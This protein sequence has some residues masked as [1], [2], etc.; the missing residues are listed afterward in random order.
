[1]YFWENLKSMYIKTLA[2]IISLTAYSFVVSQSIN[3]YG[4]MPSS[5]PN[6]D[7]IRLAE[8]DAISGD[9]ITIDSVKPVNAYAFGTSAFDS[10]H[11]AYSFIGVDPDQ[12][13]RF[14]NWG[15]YNDTMYTMPPVS[16]T[17]NDLE[18]DMQALEFYGLGSYAINAVTGEY[19]L[20]FL[21]IDQVTGE[22]NELK[23]MPEAM[24]F[25]VGSTTYGSNDG[26]YY[27][28]I[29]DN[30]FV[31]RLYAIVAETGDTNYTV[32]ITLPP[33][34]DFLNLEYNNQD[35]LI[36]G[37]LRN[38]FDNWFA[39]GSID[40]VSG[41]LADTIFEITNLQYFVQGAS[42]FH[43]M[44]QNYIL[45]YTDTDN[46]SRLLSVNVENKS[47]TSNPIVPGYLSDLQVDNY[48]YAMAAYH[49][50]VDI[51]EDSENLFDFEIYPNPVS[52]T[53][54]VDLSSFKDE[55]ECRIRIYDITT[56]RLILDEK[57]DPRYN[58]KI[59]I[60]IQAAS[61]GLHIIKVETDTKSSAQ[62]IMINN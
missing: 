48:E 21:N 58:G 51:N 18:H 34:V 60:D 57:Y 8:L 61:K 31:S 25:P 53:L 52:K 35:D 41:Y 38:Y 62:L 36:Y 43:Q 26:I 28:N 55:N 14:N 9:I 17:I 19:A 12:I 3:V 16:A 13:F 39:I 49:G 1:M 24:A 29:I 45:Y 46:N 4:I 56:S 23:K 11:Q 15:V 33:G 22:V 30:N 10:Y 59:K 2:L 7:Y 5:N 37:L 32:P 54:N 27:A 50:T 44:S 42:V 47:L 20:R 40:P 6:L